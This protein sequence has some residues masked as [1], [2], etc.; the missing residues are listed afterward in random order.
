MI[1]LLDEV[2]AVPE[3]LRDDAWLRA[4]YDAQWAAM[5]RLASLLLGGSDEAEE[6]VQDALVAV[7]A[8]RE[9][10][11]TLGHAGAYLRM[12]VV[13]GCR[14]VH[15]H[16]AVVQRHRPTPGPVPASPDDLVMEHE[17]RDQV[18][19]ALRQLPRRQQEVLVLR[20]YS[21]ASEQ[22]IADTLGISRGAVKSHAHRGMQTLRVA[23]HDT[24]KEGR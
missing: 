20:Y 6:V 19:E 8:R 4:I 15:R 18:M 3:L 9:Q 14:S 16:R 12:S 7:Y 17:T 10:F 24:V 22:E 11:E 13:N 21:E 1:A 2:L 5:V 23:L